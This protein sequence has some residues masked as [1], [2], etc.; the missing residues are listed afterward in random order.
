[1]AKKLLTDIGV[2]FE[3][4]YVIPNDT[5]YEFIKFASKK[6]PNWVKSVLN[7]SLDEI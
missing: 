3:P 6:D 1:M 4:G 5:Y 7:P 2:S